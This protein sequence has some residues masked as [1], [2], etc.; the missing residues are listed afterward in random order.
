MGPFQ[1]GVG[2][3]QRLPVSNAPQRPRGS[4]SERHK[5]EPGV[6]AGVHDAQGGQRRAESVRVGDLH[7]LSSSGK[8]KDAAISVLDY[9]RSG[10]GTHAPVV[11]SHG[12]VTRTQTPSTQLFVHLGAIVIAS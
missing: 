1:A 11:V 12:A 10:L 7:R 8:C 9:I 2:V 4:P 6:S 3:Q 5:R